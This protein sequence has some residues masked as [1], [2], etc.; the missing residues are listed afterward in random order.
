MPEKGTV[1]LSLTARLR[2]R[3]PSI[4]NTQVFSDDR[5]SKR[6]S[7]LMTASHVSWTT[8]SAT[9][10]ERTYSEATRIIAGW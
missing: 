6:S 10:G 7:P 8:S 3:L 2:A 5:P 1:R 9:D 4:R